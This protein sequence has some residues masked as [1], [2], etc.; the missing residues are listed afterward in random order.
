MPRPRLFRKI[1]FSPDVTYF[2]PQ[3]V[4]MRELEIVELTIEEMEAYRLRHLDNLEQK[5]AAKKMNTSTSTYQRILYSAYE[6]IAD[7]LIKG[8]AIKIIKN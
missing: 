4:P 6:K 7:A 1:S 3:G 8:K 5:E 2:K